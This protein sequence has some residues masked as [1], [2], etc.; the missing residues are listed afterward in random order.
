MLPRHKLE[1]MSVTTAFIT[2]AG[3]GIGRATAF[4]LAKL[5]Y[6]LGLLDLVEDAVAETASEVRARGGAAQHFAGDVTQEFDVVR[7]VQATTLAWGEIDVAVPAAGIEAYGTV[8]DLDL[9]SWHR[10]IAVNLTGTMLVARHTIRS[11]LVRGSGAFVGLSSDAGIAGSRD[12]TPYTASK[13]A[14]IG[15][16][17]CLAMDYGP[18]GIR[19]N[20]VC[21]GFV[22]TPM[23]DRIF[24][25]VGEDSAEWKSKVPLRRFCTP[26]EVANVISHL[27]S[28]EASYTNGSVYMIDGGVNVGFF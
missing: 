20:V 9:S 22:Q 3:S 15:L 11:M 7:A 10:T 13:H 4:R 24:R 21:P 6:D 19:S 16:V 23:I 25:E 26:E 2:G 14:V 5:G 12:S 17:R 27:A 8:T 1:E 28:D 18:L